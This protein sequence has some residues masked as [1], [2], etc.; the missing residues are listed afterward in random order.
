[1]KGKR[2]YIDTNIFVYVAVKHPDFFNKCNE[3]LKYLIKGEYEAYGSELIL[4]ELFGALS[5]INATAAYEAT[6]YY[7]DLPIKLLNLGR[8]TL[9]IAKEIAKESEIT[10]DAIHAAIMMENRINVIITEDLK[11]WLEIKNVWNKVAKKLRLKD[12]GD[13]LVVSPTQGTL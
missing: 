9:L 5:R 7:L 6:V 3:V 11:D 8:S 4:F 2:A 13:L 10:Y 12:I 1:M